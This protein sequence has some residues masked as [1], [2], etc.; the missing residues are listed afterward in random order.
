MLT[1]TKIRQA[2]NQNRNKRGA[3]GKDKTKK[4]QPFN[5]VLATEMTQNTPK[6]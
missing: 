2:D 6:K 5:K 1:I 3:T 4:Q